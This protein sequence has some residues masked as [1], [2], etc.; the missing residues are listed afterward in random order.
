MILHT[1]CKGSGE[2]VVFLHTGLETGSSDFAFQQTYFANDYKVIAPDLR[3][4]GQSPSTDSD[5]YFNKCSNDLRETLDDLQ[6]ARVHLVGCSLGAIVALFF[7]REYPESIQS[8]TLSG[9]LPGKPDQ[10]RAMHEESID[11]QDM[12]VKQEE[13][14]EELNSKHQSD[15]KALLGLSRSSDWY[16]FEATEDLSDLKVPVLF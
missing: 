14:R 12:M 16:P 5:D 1:N 4:H 8:L 11:R 2:T 10:W 15:W 7:A 6:I 3:G 13:V 9:L